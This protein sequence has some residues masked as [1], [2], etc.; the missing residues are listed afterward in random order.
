MLWALKYRVSNPICN[1][2][3]AD[4]IES[5]WDD[6]VATSYL[7]FINDGFDPSVWTVDGMPW[8]NV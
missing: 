3:K 8:I 2:A 1:R 7:G 6:S 4:M 5:A